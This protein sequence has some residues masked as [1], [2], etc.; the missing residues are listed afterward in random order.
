MKQKFGDY[1]LGFDIGTNSVGWAVTDLDYNV[2]RFNKKSMWGS[3]LFSEAENSSDRRTHRASRRRLKRRK[4]RIKLLQELF[5]SEISKVDTSFF[6][7]LKE[8][9]LHFEDRSVNNKYTLFMDEDFSDKDYFRNYPTIFHL[10]KAFVDGENIEDIRLLYLAIHNIIKKRG[11]FIFEGQ[12]FNSVNSLEESFNKFRSYLEDEMDI[13][14]DCDSKSIEKILLDNLSKT[15]KVNKLLELSGIK[16]KKIKQMF[17]AIVGNKANF[18]D[19][20]DDENYSDKEYKIKFSE[21]EYNEKRPDYEDMLFDRIELIDI[22]KEIYDWSILAKI[23]GSNKF[24]SQSMVSIYE[25]HEKELKDLKKIINKYDRDEYISF[26]KDKSNEKGYFAYINHEYLNVKKGALENKNLSQED[27]SK[28]LEKVFEEIEERIELEDKEVFHTLY[29]SIKERQILPKQR[30]STNGVIPYQVHKYELEKILEN[31]LENF[32]FLKEK[33]EKGF[34]IKDKIIKLLE[35]RIPYCVGP[36]N[37]YHSKDN[38]KDGFSWVV[39]KESGRVTPWNFDEKIDKDASCE[40]FITKMTNKCT[41]ILGEDV[42]P[43]DSLLYSEFKVLNEI[44]NIKL[45]GVEIDLELKK[46]IFDELLRTEKNITINKLKIFFK[47]KGIDITNFKIT[48]IDNGITSNLKNHICF[49]NLFEEGISK[50]DNKKIAESV[51]LYKCLYLDDKKAFSRKLKSLYPD[52]DDSLLKSFKKLR[53]TGWGRLSEKFL[54]EIEGV[55]KTT[56]ECFKSIIKALY[57][58]NF[59]LEQLLSDRFTFSENIEKENNSF[60]RDM[61]DYTDIIDELYLPPNLKRSVNQTVKILEEIK[62][63]TGKSPKKIFVEMAK[64]SSEDEKGKRKNSRK[65]DLIELYKYIK[66]KEYDSVT[67]ELDGYDNSALKSKKLFLYFKQLGK[68]MYSN[69]RI[70]LDS[71]FN[72]NIYD[73][74]HIYPRSKVKDDSFDNLV[75]VKKEINSS[76]SDIYPLDIEVQNKMKET[77]KTLYD[78]KLMSTKKFDRLTRK[79]GFSSDELAGFIS[80]QLVETRQSIKAVSKII[81][82]L[83]KDTDIVYLKAKNTSEF[84]HYID[85]PKVREMNNFHHAHDAYLAIVVGNVYDVKFTRNPRNFIKEYMDNEVKN[86]YSLY[87]MYDKDVKRGNVVAWEKGKT[88]GVVNK[89]LS[90]NDVLVTE[91]PYIASGA[92]F[93]E[94]KQ[95]KANKYSSMVLPLKNDIISDTS[96][97]G[98]YNSIKA[99]YFF[100]VEYRDKKSLVKSIEILPIYMKDKIKSEEDLLNYVKNDLNLIEPKII[101]KKLPCYS[102]IIFDGYPR[103]ITGK[104]GSKILIK[105]A[106]QLILD[107]KN[108]RILKDVISYVSTDEKY[109]TVKVYK[110]DRNYKKGR[111]ETKSEAEK[112]FSGEMN[113]LYNIYKFKLTEGVYKNRS[114]SVTKQVVENEEVFKNLDIYQKAFVLSELTKLFSNIAKNSVDLRFIKGKPTQGKFT[115]GKKITNK[116]VILYYESVTGLF[117]NKLEL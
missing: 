51:I 20:F 18:K 4:F 64:G 78:K 116:L 87:K 29:D 65:D 2:I 67:S 43:K 24:I 84:R 44:N 28:H 49:D 79:T 111:Y 93:N 68:C 53:F 63:I 23:L 32:E 13:I 72:E 8:S 83:F 100:V 110:I 62:S 73:I 36:L 54:K 3:R 96:K 114:E 112:R 19:M 102:K 113:E 7:R 91:M 70:E 59:N 25:K 99:A 115:V 41:Y 10:R 58:T 30:V 89:Q 39:R 107:K 109:R 55:D 26:F 5:A 27:L 15:D 95:R 74:D 35:F 85:F 22:L 37:D 69:E 105:N 92:L 66:E 48:G 56:G 77:W 106:I 86:H 104:S 97:Y 47:T 16:D 88:L 52:I 1:Y 80:R 108:I 50:G 40:K 90:R 42:I 9:M 60:S 12:D 17:T 103:I 21:I 46:Q 33:D 117:V 45:D 101:L 34:T 57:N 76:K 14:L 81:P 75:L 71:L 61:L 94:T 38:G 98:A 82:I 6:I 31:A 11:H